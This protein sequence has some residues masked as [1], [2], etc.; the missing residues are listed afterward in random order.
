MF[1]RFLAEERKINGFAS[2]RQSDLASFVTFLR[3]EIYK[4]YGK[5]KRDET[6]TIAELKKIAAAKDQTLRGLVGGTLN[7]HLGH[8]A[9]LARYARAQGIR[10]DRDLDFG[11]LRAEKPKN[12]RDRDERKK[13]P[14]AVTQR[15]FHAAHFIG[16][17]A[18][19]RPYEFMEGGLVFHRALY[20]VPMLLEYTGTRRENPVACA[21]TISMPT[22]QF[23]IFTLAGMNFAA[24]KIHSRFATFR[25]IRSCCG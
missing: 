9:Q 21:S 20:F 2:L 16:S 8:I 6:R 10:I 1:N 7:R 14:L 23:R 12:T 5:S 13:M 4:F 24:S 11:D 22:G 17:A 19:D 18:W 25:F 15:V 3:T